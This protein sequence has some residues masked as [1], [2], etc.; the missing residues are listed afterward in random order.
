MD[1]SRI[2]REIKFKATRSGGPGGQHANKVSTRVLVQ[3]DL[4]ASGGLS[5]EEKIRISER[6]SKRITEKGM[7]NLSCDSS[8]SQHKNKTMATERLM[9]LLKGALKK[10]AKRVPTK[11]SRKEKIK[12]LESKSKHAEKKAMRRPPKID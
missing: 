9:T 10:P 11:I 4:Y 2:K 7:L 5:E 12:R 3:F 1:E 6:L 8:R